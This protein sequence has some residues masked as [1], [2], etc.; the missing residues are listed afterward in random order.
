MENS[1]ELNKAE[2]YVEDED[3]NLTKF[4]GI[5]WQSRKTI[6]IG[7]VAV[8]ILGVCGDLY[9]GKYRS[10]GF[11]QFGG[12][13]PENKYTRNDKDSKESSPGITLSNYKRYIS[14]INTSER[15]SEFVKD[16]KLEND[17][18][19]TSLSRAFSSRNGISKVIEPIF[20]FTKLDAKDL[21]N[22]AKDGDNNIIA[23]NIAYAAKTPEIAQKTVSLLGRY[24]IDTITYMNYMDILRFK[25]SEILAEITKLDNKIIENKEKIDLFQRKGV[26]LKQIVTRYPE[27]ASQASRQVVSITEDT[28]RY[29]APINQLM[30]SEVEISEANEAI[31]KAKRDQKQLAIMAEYYD[32]A[33]VL[34]ESTKSGEIILRGLDPIKKAVFL[35]KDME[36]ETI[37]EVYN[38]ITV[39]ISSSLSLYLEKTRFIAGPSLPGNRTT[40]LSSV[41]FVSLIAGLCLSIFF[42]LGR[43]W[44][45][46]NSQR[47]LA[48]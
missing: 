5:L 1:G 12:S 25:K 8:S 42:V 4:L 23:V 11:L 10:E 36:D 47:L 26:K 29:L 39:D 20:P 34:A 43:R 48:S 35:N 33:K 37:K 18:I 15:F 9:L 46:E 32:R 3:F 21:M 16:E 2:I 45:R 17:P 19:A 6:I 44:W 28:A 7:T 14:S 22:G 27:A 24:T 38:K 40:R 13:I 31:Y 30:T 41:L